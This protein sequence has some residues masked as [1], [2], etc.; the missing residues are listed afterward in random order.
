MNRYRKAIVAALTGLVGLAA[1]WVPQIREVITPETI[2]AI[3][4]IAGT[5]LVWRVPNDPA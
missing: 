4:T 5:F 2:G 3:A 1:L